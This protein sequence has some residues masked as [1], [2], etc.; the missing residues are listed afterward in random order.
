MI[1]TTPF[2]EK[3]YIA[4]QWLPSHSQEVF[5]KRNPANFKEVLGRPPRSGPE[6]VDRAVAAARKAFP[7]WRRLSMIRRA[8]YL[9]TFLQI[10][11]EHLEELARL[12]TWECGKPEGRADII[13]GIHMAQ[14]C[15]GWARQFTGSVI[16]SEIP[17]KD[18]YLLRKPKGVVA[19]ITPWNFPFAIPLW[20]VLPSLVWGNTVVLKPAEETPFT[21]E[22]IAEYLHQAGLPPGVFNLIQGLG[23]E[24]GSALVRHPDVDVVLFTGSYEVGSQIRQITASDWRK[25]AAC[26]MG[27]K[28]A[29]LILE[30]ADMD[31]AV[32]AA[33]LSKYRTSGQRCT[34]VDRLIVHRSRLEEFTD[35]FLQ[36]SRKIKIGDP[37][38]EEV[39]MGPLI[40]Q[41]AVEKVLYYNQLARE[42]GAEVLLEGGRLSGLSYDKGWFVSPFVYQMA[43]RSDSRVLRE[44]VFGP[45][46]AIIPVDSLE[47]AIAV[48]NDTDYGLAMAVITEDYRKMRKVREECEFGVGY[49]NL[50]TIGAEV[51]LPFG[52]VKKS[53]S[54]FPAGLT[55]IDAV[56]HRIAFTYNADRQIQLPQGL[57]A[58]F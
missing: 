22:R 13:E 36:A 52:G 7:E 34:A 1:P 43:H 54:G 48:H 15:I 27:G 26:E 14:M 49:W 16:P 32:R 11:K 37:L 10:V 19:V 17:T 28:N 2:R 30:D 9:E 39:F 25:I 38:K 47:E 53:G 33:V 40:N 41:Q 35:R 5:E 51:Q 20:G 31:L 4:G 3:N 45:H 44:E 23:E 21:A 57:S 56:T 50:P 58:E 12:V 6:D 42:E 18:S 46:V 29:L 24:A 55:I 8:E